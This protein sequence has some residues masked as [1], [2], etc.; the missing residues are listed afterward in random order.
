MDDVSR[1]PRSAT[2][3]SSREPVYLASQLA[4]ICDVDLK[5]IHNWCD[6]NDDP[7]GP[8]ALE[9]FRTPGGHLRF[10]H[11]AVLRFLS[12][13]GYPIP[14]ALLADRPHVLLVEPDAYTR[15]VL[16]TTLDLARPG[17]EPADGGARAEL[18]DDPSATLGLWSTPRY[19]L[20]VLEDPYCALITLGERL[21]AGS[22][23]DLVVLGLPLPGLDES[24]FI[25]VASDNADD[26]LR[27]V[28]LTSDDAPAS[29]GAAGVVGVVP[30]SKL[31]AL[32][33][34]LD[35]QCALLAAARASVRGGGRARRRRVPIAPREPI[36]VA[37][38]VAS[39]WDVD[40]KTVHTWV[41]RGDIEAFRT[42][43]RHLRFRRR[44]L[45]HFLRRYTMAIPPD[46]APERPVVML[47]GLPV[48]SV[49]RL[50]AALAERFDLVVIDDVVGALVE[51]GLR[52]SGASLVDAVVVALPAAGVDDA[53]WVSALQQH[54]DTRYTRLV[55]VGGSDDQ[56]RR[57]QS[58]G[59][60]TTL[61][62]DS[63]DLVSVVLEK[64]LGVG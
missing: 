57:W 2:D 42:P 27:F 41:E 49:E 9:S 47:A 34:L 22:P 55:V 10:R 64:S 32:G 63:L 13:W 54:D 15:R 40:L 59:A 20:H 18:S 12:R 11:A 23:P 48:A 16:A 52:S 3:K 26:G 60:T 14:D 39:I 1:K 29:A 51:A 36:Y 61:H 21:G 53:A 6:R 5:T 24:T 50:R 31:T 43:G 58:L 28:L 44:S 45:L 19:Y 17:E 37:S 46:L 56:Q 33:A 4:S 8:A 38:Q 25:R 30:R 7:D 35:E 62:P